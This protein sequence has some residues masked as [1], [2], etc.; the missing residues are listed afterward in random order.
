MQD[1]R[2]FLIHYHHLV[3]GTMLQGELGILDFFDKVGS[4]QYDPLNVVGRNADLVL[5]SRIQDYQASMLNSLL[6]EKRKLLDG[7]D[8]M[9]SIYQQK[10]WPYFS[11]IRHAMQESIKADLAYR[12]SLEALELADEVKRIILD[13]GPLQAKDISLGAKYSGSWGH[14]KMSSATLDYM[15]HSGVIGVAKKRNTQKV[16]DVIE[17]LIPKE[18]LEQ[19]EPFFSEEAFD[20]WYFKRRLASVGLLWGKSGGGWLGYHLSDASRRKTILQ[21]LV[22][23]GEIIPIKV[24]EIK[25]VFYIRKEEEAQLDECIK[26]NSYQDDIIPKGIKI[27]APLDNLL[28]DRSM[29]ER[30]FGFSYTWEVY[31]PIIKRKYGYYVLPVLYK[32]T[33]IARFEPKLQRNNEPLNIENWWWEA[34][35]NK[36]PEMFQAIITGLE[37]FCTY[38]GAPSFK[39]P[40]ELEKELLPYSAL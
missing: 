30:L 8:K 12:D 6:Y 24:G 36:T 35:T 28:W 2:R 13:K 1:A 17:A 7:W 18:I 4:I 9:L 40:I 21:K 26:K 31:V 14:K 10:D 15:Y 16:Y 11:R 22:E 38:L 19:E 29:I 23:L 37:N 33:F 39:L 3:D 5:Q 25:E 32:D 20:L 34:E 27:L